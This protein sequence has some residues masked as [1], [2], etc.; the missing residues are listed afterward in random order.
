MHLRSAGITLALAV[1][2]ALPAAAGAATKTVQVGPPGPQQKAFQDA[3]GDGNAF[4][5]RVITIHKNDSVRWQLNGFHTVTFVPAGEPLPGLLVPDASNLV[6]GL[7]DAANNPFW[8]NG[9]PTVGFNLQAA[10]PQGGKTLNPTAIENSGLP[11]AP[12]APPPYKLKFKKKGTFSYV[13][14]V[15]PGMAGKVKV[16]G[17]A[18]TIPS[19]RKDK[20]AAAR[21]VKATL[22]RVQRLTTGL[23]TEDLDKTI[24][25]G[26]DRL[27]GATV[28]RFFPPNPTYKVGDTVTL[29]MSPNST[30]AHTLTFGPTNGK[31]AYNDVLAA[32]FEGP[33]PDARAIYPSEPPPAGIPSYN[34]ANHGNGF[35]NSGALDDDAASPLPTSTKVT[36]TGPGTFSLI[37]LIHPFMTN[38]VTVTP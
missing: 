28:Y 38:T 21:E 30:E 20:R 5:R 4:F 8:F 23:G 7:N 26:N 6:T 27:S 24:Q 33:A 22:E 25:A 14:L 3:F 12:G 37:C 2:L 36:F 9:Q 10:L 15:H 11:L 16:V 19:A 31:D 29:R 13:C 32:S 34:G 18:R 1:S 17:A 35:F